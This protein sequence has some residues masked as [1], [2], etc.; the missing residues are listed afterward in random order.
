MNVLFCI[1]LLVSTLLKFFPIFFPSKM[2]TLDRL[3]SRRCKR[4]FIFKICLSDKFFA[5]PRL[6][7][8]LY[9]QVFN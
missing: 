5:I 8:F 9:S 7:A 2:V 3:Y 1:Q 4:K 6:V